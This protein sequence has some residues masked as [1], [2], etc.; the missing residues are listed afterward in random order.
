[1]LN[2]LITPKPKLVRVVT[3]SRV[4]PWHLE[5]TLVDLQE[6]YE[7]IVV[8][9]KVSSF[10]SDSLNVKYYNIPIKP[11]I[12]L[13][14]DLYALLFLIFVVLKEKPKII[15]SIMPKAGLLTALAAFFFVPI[16]IHTFT[17][18]VW[19]TK[20]GFSKRFL[21]LLD[22]LVVKLNTRCLTDSPSQS[23]YLM[24]E[25]ISENNRPLSY[26]LKGSLGGVDLLKINYE[27]KNA[28]RQE[29]RDKFDFK[30]SDF[31]VG[32]LA[33]KTIDKGALFFLENCLLLINSKVN[34]KFFFIGPSDCRAVASF[35]KNHPE[36]SVHVV[37][38]GQ[39]SGHEKFLAA[40]DVLSIPSFREGF[41][42]VV[43]D[44]AALAV[45]CIG[46]RI[47][48]LSDAIVDGYT[49]LLFEAGSNKEYVDCINSFYS[50]RLFLKYC[51]GNAYDNVI[52]YYDSKLLSASLVDFYRSL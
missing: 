3:D 6:F 13:I 12:N 15:H 1:M 51:S 43:I 46:S 5:K 44:A 23:D 20:S 48:G 21:K 14:I 38:I 42:S 8:G 2:P 45:P 36:L 10:K 40:F 28:W 32:Y 35:F 52:K 41:G 18:Q 7:L 26:L 30:E 19:Q 37:N 34:I 22:G 4:I 39:V 25:G 11:K 47:S 31:V 50:N 29:I 16:R 33:R 24:S 49:G 27:L 9:D 17:G